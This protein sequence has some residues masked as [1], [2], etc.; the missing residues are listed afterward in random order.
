MGP[1]HTEP[2]NSSPTCRKLKGSPRVDRIR[3]R[4]EGCWLR[5]P[6]AWE[7][8]SF[9]EHDQVT[10][11]PV[12]LACTVRELLEQPFSF[13]PKDGT[14]KIQAG[15]GEQGRYG[16]ERDSHKVASLEFNIVRLKHLESK[17]WPTRGSHPSKAGMSS[18]W[19]EASCTCSACPHT[20]VQDVC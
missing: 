14:P 1:S 11:A 18:L 20:Q 15:S 17:S 9:G 4:R 8:V 16:P 2:P 19:H 7:T 3:A 6:A 12:P 13:A 10:R 5:A